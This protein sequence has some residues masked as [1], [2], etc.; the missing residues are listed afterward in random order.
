MAM[1]LA[2]MNPMVGSNGTG[3][4]RGNIMI[5]SLCPE[6]DAQWGNY[7]VSKTLDDNDNRLTVD[8]N[9][10]LCIKDKKDLSESYI[11][12]YYILNKDSDEIFNKLVEETMLPYD[13]RPVR[14]KSYLYEVFTDHD[15]VI[16]DQMRYDPLLEEIEL[17]KFSKIITA[18]A[19]NLDKQYRAEK[20][21]K[22][23]RYIPDD[24][25]YPIMNESKRNEATMILEK[26]GLP[27]IAIY[28]DINGFYGY[29]SQTGDRTYS[30]K[31][32]K[33]ILFETIIREE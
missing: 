27:Y 22:E 16:P 31:D 29:N 15:M 19:Y 28:E 12:A 13:S 2:S 25:G 10:K 32:I 33:D 26:I 17:E 21:K 8:D 9:G 7:S 4:N 30:C 3:L 20:T 24:P 14:S 11:A 1:G 6:K 23:G 5:N 18:D